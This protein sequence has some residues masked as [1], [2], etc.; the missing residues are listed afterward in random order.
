MKIS[1]CS[2]ALQ[3]SEQ[4]ILTQIAS[5]GLTHIDY[6]PFDFRSDKSKQKM[7]DLGLIPTCIATGFGMPDNVALDS[8]DPS[9]RLVAFEHTRASLEYADQSNVRIAYMLTGK[10]DHAD[11]L[12]FY[13]DGTSKLADIAKQYGIKLCIEH[14]PGTTLPTIQSTLNF[15]TTLNHT[16][17]FLLL[18]IGH[19][20]ISGE[21]PAIAVTMAGNRLGYFH[22]DDNEGKSDLHWGLLD[23]ILTENVLRTTLQALTNIGYKEPLSIEI[24]PKLYDPLATISQSFQLMNAIYQ[25]DTEP[26]SAR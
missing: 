21:D 8:P 9:A 17:L 20:Q 25:S 13:G 6:R 14:F 3:G 12:K 19:A 23:G 2:W 5:T 15:I 16:D 7:I 10:G 22:L 11:E 18:D 24:S 26:S 1:C 4:D